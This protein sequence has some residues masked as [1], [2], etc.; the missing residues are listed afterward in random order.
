MGHGSAYSRE[1]C[2]TEGNFLLAHVLGIIAFKIWN[3]VSNSYQIEVGWL[4]IKLI[5]LKKIF[6]CKFW[7]SHSNLTPKHHHQSHA[8][9]SRVEISVE[10]KRDKEQVYHDIVIIIKKEIY[11]SQFWLNVGQRCIWILWWF[12]M[13][14]SVTH[15]LFSFKFQHPIKCCYFNKKISCQ[16]P[17]N[18]LDAVSIQLKFY[19]NKKIS[20]QCPSNE[21][22]AVASNCCKIF[23]TI[24][25]STYIWYMLAEKRVP[26]LYEVIEHS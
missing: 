17:S 14:S 10:R 26:A 13:C 7:V 19:F 21:L 9:W 1:I 6:S 24:S 20:C 18:E 4:E 23:A 5:Q 15:L 2:I 25:Q 16:C 11:Q 3:F 22:D 8:L 12:T